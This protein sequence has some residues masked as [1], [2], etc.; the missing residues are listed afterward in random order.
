MPDVPAF[1]ME[2]DC[3]FDPPPE[4]SRI[5]AECPV[6]RV[7]LWDGSHPWLVTGYDDQRAVLADHR[8]SADVTRPGYPHVTAASAARRKRSRAFISMD[9]PEHG[10]Y[11]KMLTGT[12]MIKRVEALRPRIQRI[13]DDL[14]DTL[15]AGTSPADLVANFALPVPS[16]VICEL[17]GVPYADHDFF[18]RCSRILVSTRSTPLEA[19]TAA[20]ELKDYLSRLLERKSAE[21]ADDLLSRL[22][23]EQSGTLTRSQLADMALLLLVAGHETTANMIG[24]GTLTLLR[25]PD[26]LAELRET[27]DPKVVA[28]AVEELLRY[29]NIVHSGR[30]RV[31]TEDVEVGGRLIR[32]GEGVIVTTDTGNRDASAF[33]DPDVLDIHRQARHHVAF[34]YGVHQC[35][36][37]PLARV[38]LQVVYGTLYRRI[39]T[40][41]LAVPLEEIRFKH[42]M[43]VYGVHELPVSW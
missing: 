37:Q 9:E 18:Q 28:G 8:F 34:G 26:Q 41:R 33:P 4:L 16:L 21:P 22:V 19:T 43:L 2:R 13:V 32:A 25:H 10:M 17:L 24:L 23:A 6:S 14:I 29:L 40:L 36:G 39:P 20:D 42:D 12:F 3:P 7:R 38:E 5:R 27:E 30:R 15:L 31:A 35:L 1:P 11:R